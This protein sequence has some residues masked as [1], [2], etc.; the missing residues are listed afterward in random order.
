MFIFSSGRVHT[1]CVVLP[2]GSTF[3]ISSVV[4]TEKLRIQTLI[5]LVIGLG[6]ITHSVYGSRRCNKNKSKSQKSQRQ[7]T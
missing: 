4:Q 5:C 6:M 7:V 3:V 2:S 1:F